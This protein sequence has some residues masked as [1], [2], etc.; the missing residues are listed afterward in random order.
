VLPHSRTIQIGIAV[1]ASAVLA[2]AA[3]L[4]YA[5]HLQ[6]D[7]CLSIAAWPDL[8]TYA[9]LDALFLPHPWCSLRL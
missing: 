6:W 8:H 7:R 5:A 3:L 4:L 1:M 2:G 9:V